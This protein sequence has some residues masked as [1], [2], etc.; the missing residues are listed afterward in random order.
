MTGLL[1]SQQEVVAELAE[2]CFENYKKTPIDRKI[3]LQ[4]QLDLTNKFRTSI[5][6][7]R[8]QFSPELIDVLLSNFAFDAKSI[9]DPFAGSGT[10]VLESS[11]IMKQCVGVELNPAAYF[12]AKNLEFI[13]LSHSERKIMLDRVHDIIE[14]VDLEIKKKQSVIDKFAVKTLRQILQKTENGS[15]TNT[16]TTNVIMR[17]LEATKDT[18]LKK[19]FLEHRK[20]IEDLP[21]SDKPC[22]ILH[23]DSRNIMVEDSSIDVI[24][25]SPPYIN[26]FNYHQN[27]RRAMELIGWNILDIAKSEFGSNRKNRGN[28]FFT[29]TQYSIDMLQAL[30][31]M[32][33]VIAKNGRI[34]III[35]RESKV[36]G[37][38]FDNG[39]IVSALAEGGA[40]LKLILRQE[41]SF[42]NKFGQTIY[43]EILHFTL[44]EMKPVVNID[45]VVASAVLKESL[46]RVDSQAVRH[47]I[48]VA[49]EQVAKIKPSHL[50]K[51]N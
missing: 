28:R 46:Q 32:R 42:Q 6:S 45:R 26:V 23:G 21:Y 1:Q 37:V 41:R 20:I 33:R 44:S 16:I 31:E 10:T 50:F 27:Y 17:F 18:S 36:R 25:T 29:V 7:W 48:E 19:S 22:T 9:L 34:I 24:I 51:L 2:E 12:L 5:F 39:K 49:I 8:G 38:S 3:I 13:N 47:G 35:G 30:K 43:E 15:Y 4:E 14:N 40:Q 11:R